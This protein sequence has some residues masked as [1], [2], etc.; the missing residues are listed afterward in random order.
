MTKIKI[1]ILLLFLLS[2]TVSQAQTISPSIITPQGSSYIAG[3]NQLSWTTGGL[4]TQTLTAGGYILTQSFEQPELQ[5]WTGSIGPSGICPG[6]TINVPY[7]QS[8]IVSNSNNFVA[9]LSN[10]A[11]SFASPVTVGTLAGKINGTIACS[12]PLTTPAGS[13]YRIRVRSTLPAF[14]GPNN[15]NNFS[16]W[17]KPNCNISAVPENNVYT[18][19][20]PTNIYL[21][22]GP[23]QLTLNANASGGA[24]FS[25][26][27]S[28]S[29]GLSCYNCATPV[30]AATSAGVYN[31][32][33]TVTNANGCKSTC[34]ISICVTDI[35]SSG[36]KVYVCHNGNSLSVSPNAVPAHFPGH[37]NDRLG[38][39]NQQQSCAT[40]L[41][42]MI[43]KVDANVEEEME[44][45]SEAFTV[46]AMPNPTRDYFNL[47]IKSSNKA[48]LVTVRILD[49]Y[50]RVLLIRTAVDPNTILR[51]GEK[52]FAGTY[53]VNVIQDKTE[54]TV[55][56]IKIN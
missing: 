50:G 42:E 24:P 6:S 9:E 20:I 19:G 44:V 46:T 22:Y 11:G 43:T 33:L 18:G 39:C 4:V 13:G 7:T 3:G 2:T 23:Q 10:A 55:K 1:R 16:V 32:T 34:S 52:L 49:I 51:L 35:R 40:Q 25:Y 45:I 12:I 38:R 21:G 37:A 28:G 41:A 47:Q 30:F 8:G 27:W 26:S 53:L 14:T 5:V 31:F 15:G 56:V 29:G 48:S 17:A 54:R 36:N